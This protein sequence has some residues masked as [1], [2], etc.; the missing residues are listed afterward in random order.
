MTFPRIS[1]ASPKRTTIFGKRILLIPRC[2]FGDWKDAKICL[3][4]E[5]VTTTVHSASWTLVQSPGYGSVPM[6][7]TTG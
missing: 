1:N 4:F 6:Q 5:L 7:I 3:Q 2:G